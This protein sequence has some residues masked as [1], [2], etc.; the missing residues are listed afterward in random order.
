M[1]FTIRK[2]ELA[3]CTAIAEFNISMAMETEGRRLDRDTIQA[4][5]R[6]LMSG[7]EYGFYLITEFDKEIVASLLITYEWSDWRDGLF[8]WIQSVYVKPDFR[9]QGIYRKFYS[10]VKKM[11]ANDPKV[12]GFRLYVDTNNLTARKTYENLGM[13]E[14]HYA[15]YE[16]LSSN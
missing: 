15:M 4:G 8:W 12:R 11:A 9:R 7:P 2:A 6:N 5:V 3:H 16:E 1:K 13:Q 10:Y 14:A